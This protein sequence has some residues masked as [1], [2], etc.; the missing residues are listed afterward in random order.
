MSNLLV[1]FTVAFVLSV[2][3]ACAV[4]VVVSLGSVTGEEDPPWRKRK[5]AATRHVFKGLH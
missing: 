3:A 1:I 5:W 4:G 2:A